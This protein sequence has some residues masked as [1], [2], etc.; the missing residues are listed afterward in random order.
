[1]LNYSHILAAHGFTQPVHINCSNQ[2]QNWERHVGLWMERGAYLLKFMCCS[3]WF[4]K[5]RTGTLS[6]R[7]AKNW[8]RTVPL[9]GFTVGR[10]FSDMQGIN[11]RIWPVGFQCLQIQNKIHLELLCWLYTNLCAFIQTPHFLKIKKVNPYNF[12]SHKSKISLCVLPS[13]DQTASPRCAQ[14]PAQHL[15]TNWFSLSKIETAK[16]ERFQIK[17]ETSYSTERPHTTTAAPM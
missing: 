4:P 12:S 8:G 7:R 13:W 17:K 2:K 11:P 3:A 5:P 9:C 1:M 6:H 15:V 14:Q 16:H 10:S